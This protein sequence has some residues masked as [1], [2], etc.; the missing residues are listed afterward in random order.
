M[1]L[2]RERKPGVNNPT[3]EIMQT[4]PTFMDFIVMTWLLYIFFSCLYLGYV[5]RKTIRPRN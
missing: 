3:R 5:V 1:A 2:L 4:A